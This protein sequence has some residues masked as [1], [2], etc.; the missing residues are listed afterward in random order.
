MPKSILGHLPAGV[1]SKSVALTGFCEGLFITNATKGTSAGGGYSSPLQVFRPAMRIPK[2][3]LRRRPGLSLPGDILSWEV[4]EPVADGFRDES[5]PRPKGRTFVTVRPPFTSFQLE[6]CYTPMIGSPSSGLNITPVIEPASSLA[7][8]VHALVWAR[9][10]L[11]K[12]TKNAVEQRNLHI[13]YL[14]RHR[15]VLGVYPQGRSTHEA[16]LTASEW[17]LLTIL[18]DDGALTMGRRLQLSSKT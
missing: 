10:S 13:Q 16:L 17:K 1:H 18:L 9:K 3:R 6:F 14:F 5:E 11:P 2:T 15:F 7:Y 12:L 8:D 4:L